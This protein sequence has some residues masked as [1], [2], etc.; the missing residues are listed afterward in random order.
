M[1][2]PWKLSAPISGS[3]YNGIGGMVS[4]GPPC[5]PIPLFAQLTSNKVA[6]IIARNRFNVFLS[7]TK[8]NLKLQE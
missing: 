5:G 8:P 2:S 3:E 1:R 6:P 4:F 7:F